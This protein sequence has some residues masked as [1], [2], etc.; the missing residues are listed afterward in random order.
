MDSRTSADLNRF[1]TH[2]PLDSSD[3]VLVVLKGHLLVEEL[4][5][6]YIDAHVIR[7]D[8]LQDA[9]LTFHQC[10]CLA[11]AFS[12]GESNEKLWDS[13]EKLNGL[14]NKLAHSLEP[15]DVDRRIKEFVE[16]L[17]NAQPNAIYADQD[18]KFGV[19]STCIL[20]ICLS[21]SVALRKFS[22]P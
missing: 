9:R 7:A 12:D 1:V 2:L 19:L 21:L 22:R 20:T 3:R 4:L 6:E 16:V 18:Q 11:R 17:S 8:K 5:R 10:L 13:I 14:R 15:K